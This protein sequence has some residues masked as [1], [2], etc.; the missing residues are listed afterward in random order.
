MDI[1]ISLNVLKYAVFKDKS[2]L[3][4]DIMTLLTYNMLTRINY[5]C[6]AYTIRTQSNVEIK[7]REL[8]LIAVNSTLSFG[9]SPTL[10]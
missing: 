10:L 4:T 5:I 9:V 7:A 8:L 3:V 2:R 6:R 1:S